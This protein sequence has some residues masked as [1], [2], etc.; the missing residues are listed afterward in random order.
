RPAPIAEA[1]GLGAAI[2]YLDGIG[3][4]AIERHE[5]ELLDYALR[6][7]EA[8]DGVRVFGPPADRRAGIVS[9]EVEG[10]HPHDVAQVLDWE[11]VAVR[12]APHS[13]PPRMATLG[14]P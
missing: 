2:D 12:P 1:G 6:K 11:G 8:L 9:F 7:L 4:E 13:H 10:A 3:V 14:V 5:R